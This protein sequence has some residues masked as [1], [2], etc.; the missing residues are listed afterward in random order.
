MESAW[1]VWSI[2]VI[3]LATPRLGY[4]VQVEEFTDDEVETVAITYGII[5]GLNE[6]KKL[7]NEARREKRE[8]TP[9]QDLSR[10]QTTNLNCKNSVEQLTKK[11]R[12]KIANVP[13]PAGSND[14]ATLATLTK[15]ERAIRNASQELEEECAWKDS[16]NKPVEATRTQFLT[17][18]VNDMGSEGIVIYQIGI[19]RLE[20][21]DP[22]NR[23]NRP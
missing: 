9:E 1:L 14:Q 7:F 12:Q 8:V 10:F 13:K 23:P 22:Y 6:V 11:F 16:I 15:I 5:P 19:Q 2:L 21:E 3:L 17:T 4:A 20:F 18:E